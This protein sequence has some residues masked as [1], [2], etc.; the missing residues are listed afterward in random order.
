MIGEISM[1]KY[2]IRCL[3]SVY[4]DLSLKLG[5]ESLHKLAN[6]Q[7]NQAFMTTHNCD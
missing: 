3:F 4:F 6:T 5:L 7:N 2:K 1:I